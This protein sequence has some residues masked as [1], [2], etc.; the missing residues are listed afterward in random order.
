VRLTPKKCAP[1]PRE[2]G[3]RRLQEELPL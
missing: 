1:P 3:E 2:G